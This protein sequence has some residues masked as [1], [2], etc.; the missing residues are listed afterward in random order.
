MNSGG[1]LIY[2][3][4]TV[5]SCGSLL[6][7][8]QLSPT[9]PLFLSSVAAQVAS[10]KYLRFPPLGSVGGCWVSTSSPFLLSQLIQFKGKRLQRCVP[11]NLPLLS[12][13]WSDLV[14]HQGPAHIVLPCEQCATLLFYHS[15]IIW[16]FLHLSKNT[17]DTP[18]PFLVLRLLRFFGFLSCLTHR[19]PLH[20][21]HTG[22]ETS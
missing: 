21:R 11:S 16:L 13:S 18:S 17:F 2:R 5:H 20:R 22:P 1:R 19:P 6:S 9:S 10:L 3:R 4:Q 7:P 12:T 14:G 8:L 15:I